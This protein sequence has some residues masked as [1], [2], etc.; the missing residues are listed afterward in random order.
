[1]YPVDHSKQDVEQV[2]IQYIA[3]TLKYST[4]TETYPQ[5]KQHYNILIM[6]LHY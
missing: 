6:Q 2:K 4:V 3:F 5:N 1:M